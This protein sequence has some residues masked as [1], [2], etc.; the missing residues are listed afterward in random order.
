MDRSPIIIILPPT[1][2]ESSPPQGGTIPKEGL[3]QPS[4]EKNRAKVW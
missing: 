4:Q 1:F 3:S 2:V